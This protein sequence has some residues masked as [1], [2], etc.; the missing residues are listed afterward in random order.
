MNK[1]GLSKDQV[2]KLQLQFGRNALPEKEL[3]TVWSIFFSQFKG[4][5]V[6]ILITVFGVSLA[7]K[8]YLDAALVVFV[9]LVDVSMGFIQEY[10]AKRSLAALKKIIKPRCF[11]LR[12]SQRTEVETI[13]LVPGDLVYLGA[14][15][16]VPADGVLVSSTD[17]LVSEAILTG[18]EEPVEKRTDTKSANLFMGTSV[19][20][21]KGLLR[22]VSIGS[23]TEIGK[24]GKDLSEIPESPTPLQIRLE[25]F[26]KALG[27]IVIATSI[28]ILVIGLLTGH[29]FWEMFRFSIILSFAAIPTGLDIAVTVVLSLG[30]H[31][32]LKQ[33]ALVK[34]LL[35][36]ETLGSTTVIC[37]D[38]TGTLTEGVMEVT[39]TEFVNSRLALKGLIFL[40][41]RRTSLE[42]AIWNFLKKQIGNQVQTILAKNEIIYEE[43]FESIKKYALT[44]SKYSNQEIAF[45]IGAPEVI[46]DFCTINKA[47][48]VRIELK[49]HL[50][51][52]QGLRVVCLASKSSGNLKQKTHFKWLGIIGIRDPLRKGAKAALEKAKT[53]GI[54]IKIV[55]GD[56]IQTA[57]NVAKELGI[58]AEKKNII[59]GHLLEKISLAELKERISEITLFT[60]VSP[61]QKLKIVEALQANGEVVA[62]TGDGINDA[63]ALKKADIGIVVG[64]ATDV[65]RETADLVLLD[66]NF[67]TI[68]AAVE[69]GRIIFANIKKVVGYVL[70][71]SFAEIVLIFGALLLDIPFP[72]TV[73]QILWL[74]LICDGPPDIVLGFEP[75]EPG[76]MA[77]KPKKFLR[78][79]ILSASMFFL[80]II[81][82]FTAGL[83]ALQAFASAYHTSQNIVLA[84]TVAFAI[85]GSIDLAYI[86]AYKDLR[87]TI[88]RMKN[89]F[90]NKYLI[91]SVVYGFIILLSGIYLPILNRVLGTSPLPPKYWIP[92][93][94]G[95]VL[96][97]LWVE[98]VKVGSNFFSRKPA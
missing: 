6:Y 14:G 91:Y 21:G 8:E 39:Q 19:L 73:V 28:I 86:F 64:T 32:I 12:D 53:A 13:D 67:A 22:I 5:F 62:M 34:K 35:S 72:L 48:R 59:E 18:E 37:T 47:E 43:V 30:M 57:V 65:A 71:N 60:R 33:K 89:F 17:L 58:P 93:L 90:E 97:T 38:K 9:I 23:K 3:E 46:L 95:A 83:L 66:S 31:R 7:F 70:S 94:V 26:S 40:N 10:R 20:S 1:T 4:P 2:L 15:D 25:Q 63:P 96:S 79:S 82:S 74:H 92:V 49:Q 52:S 76:I 88:F 55:T 98:I 44:V 77:E 54:A 87:R 36:I 45:A 16:K 56:Y 50:W 11:V 84:R 29:D 85:I 27:Y 80:I 42:I 68:V 69:E 75:K 78:E 61:H 41:T 24:I 51:S 81:I